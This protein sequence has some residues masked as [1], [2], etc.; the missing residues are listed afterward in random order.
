M[1]EDPVLDHRSISHMGTVNRIR[2]QRLAT[3]FL[4]PVSQPYYAAAFSDTGKVNIYNVRPMIE[5][6]DV[7]G[8]SFAMRSTETPVHMINAHRVEGY[9]MDWNA[10]SASSLSL[11]TGD[12]DSKIYLTTASN[13]DF[14]LSPKPFESHESSVEDLQWSPTE[15]TVFA[16]CSTDQSIRIWD[17]RSKVR[18]SI[19]CISGAH[20][21]DI[22]SISWNRS[23]SYLLVSGDD[24][25]EIKVWDLRSIKESK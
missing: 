3:P 15:I 14:R 16:S 4:P 11:L 13:A 9:A 25:G 19:A 24:N 12:N 5:S 17:V 10:P 2:A 8:Y 22:N 1:D 7:P 20:D 18:Q 23:T 6:I 21:S